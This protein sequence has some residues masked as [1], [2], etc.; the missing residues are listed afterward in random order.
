MAQ[1]VKNLPE[2]RRRGFDPWVGKIAWKREWLLTPLFLPG[3]LSWTEEP[4]MS[5]AW[6]EESMESQSVGHDLATEQQQY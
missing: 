5:Q 2:C 4:G 1:T 3:E 6:T